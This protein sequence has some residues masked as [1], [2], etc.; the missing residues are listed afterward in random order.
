MQHPERIGLAFCLVLALTAPALAQVEQ[1]ALR[2]PG[3]ACGAC[4]AIAEIGL[5]RL[6]SV[7]KV[8]ISRSNEAVT[9]SHKPNAA[10]E[11]AEI[12]GVLEPLGVAIAEWQVQARG[13]V[14]N[15]GGKAFFVAGKDRFALAYAHTTP[16]IAT[17]AMVRIEGVVD[18]RSNPMR[19]T[20]T[21]VKP[22]R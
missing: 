16:K 7:D 5:R 15:E 8:T 10:F 11:A 14:L 1:T 17:G 9:I 19:L 20:V 22:L 12:R 2:T 13:R 3:I 18:D 4:A 21:A 6:A